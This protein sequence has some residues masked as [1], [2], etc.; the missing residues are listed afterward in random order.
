MNSTT[1][2]QG[3]NNR[4]AL[5]NTHCCSD[6]HILQIINCQG[7][8]HPPPQLLLLFSSF[9]SITFSAS[10]S[11]LHLGGVVELDWPLITY[12]HILAVFIH[13]WS[14]I[15]QSRGRRRAW[16]KLVRERG[17][18]WANWGGTNFLTGP[19]YGL[20]GVTK[21][22]LSLRNPS[23][24]GG[25]GYFVIHPSDTSVLWHPDSLETLKTEAEQWSAQVLEIKDTNPGTVWKV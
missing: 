8:C 20:G 14:A 10:L 23:G 7:S 15:A 16:S 6:C 3:P 18:G 25:G 12:W 24:L 11:L 4:E 5:R 19:W 13:E 17:G 2:P 21:L 9:L 22:G 1:R